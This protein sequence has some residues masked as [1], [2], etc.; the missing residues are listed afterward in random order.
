MNNSFERELGGF[1][2]RHDVQLKAFGVVM[3]EVGLNLLNE[4]GIVGTV[5]IQPKDR[6]VSCRAGARHGQLYPVLDGGILDLAHAEHVSL[7]YLLAHQRLA[8]G[9]DHV[10]PPACRDLEGLVV[11]PVFLGFLGHE[12]HVGDAPHGGGIQG[13]VLLAKVNRGLVH[14]G[15]G[16]IGNDGDRVLGLALGI[17]HLAPFANH[18]RHGCVND[19]V[20]GH[21]EVG[22]SLVGVDHGQVRA[23]G[24]RLRNGRFNGRTLRRVHLRQ[25]GHEVAES[26]VEVHASR[27]KRGPM[28][29]NHW[30]EEGPHRRPEQDG[31]GHLHHG[32]LHVKREQ[33]TGGLDGVNFRGKECFELGHGKGGTVHH[34]AGLKGKS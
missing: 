19:D 26:V 17:P 7:V 8:L 3:G 34:L 24:H 18:R 13:A 11:R 28:L 15:V 16:A 2:G 5:R 21:V 10:D 9:V 20:G 23:H 33:G 14:A 31:V 6:R 32:G 27:F 30:I 25:L 22:D 1:R 12:S 4:L 29:V